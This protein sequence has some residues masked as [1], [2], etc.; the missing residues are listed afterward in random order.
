G[1]LQLQL[2]DHVDVAVADEQRFDVGGGDHVLHLGQ[3]G[4]VVEG[5][6]GG[7]E[8]GGGVIRLDEL[9]TVGL[10]HG[11]AVARLDPQVAQTTRESAHPVQG[12]AV[13]QAGAFENNDFLLGKHHAGNT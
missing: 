12:I 8:G 6:E 5:D 3:L 13:R 11:H 10:E 4:P 2:F 1:E 9:V 7:A